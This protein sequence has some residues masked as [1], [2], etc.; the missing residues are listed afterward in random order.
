MTDLIAL[1]F[2]KGDND[3]GNYLYVYIMLKTLILNSRNL[4]NI[5]K[6]LCNKFY[7]K[8]Y[9]YQEALVVDLDTFD[10]ELE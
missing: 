5:F 6:L 2:S 4:S 7:V 10:V 9:F 3:I 8:Q 1:V